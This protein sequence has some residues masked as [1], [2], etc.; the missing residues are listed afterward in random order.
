MLLWV[1]LQKRGG[2][3]TDALKRE[4]FD[5]ARR[6]F[7]NMT[8]VFHVVE[9]R[10]PYAPQWPGQLRD[11]HD[12]PIWTAAVNARVNVVL[13]ENLKDGPPLDA[14]GIRSWGRVMYFHPDAFIAFLG[15]LGDFYETTRTLD[16]GSSLP[17]ADSP[18]GIEL[19]PE[20]TTFLRIIEA[21]ARED[22]PGTGGAVES[23]GDA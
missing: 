12:R 6:W 19:S 14:A 1:W 9:D 18:A 11:E 8:S 21:Q 16:A 23:E 22:L 7:D 5:L 17:P 20:I 13:T 3:M 10:P 15:E 4:A 2:S